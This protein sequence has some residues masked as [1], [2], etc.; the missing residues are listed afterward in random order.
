MCW[1]CSL[2]RD[3]LEWLQ[4]ATW[5]NVVVPQEKCFVHG[6][7]TNIWVP[8]FGLEKEKWAIINDKGLQSTMRITVSW[9]TSIWFINLFICG[10]FEWVRNIS[11][12]KME[13]SHALSL[14][15]PCHTANSHEVRLKHQLKF[16]LWHL[17]AF[18]DLLHLWNL[19]YKIS[20]RSDVLSLQNQNKSKPH[21]LL[22]TLQA[23]PCCTAHVNGVSWAGDICCCTLPKV[24]HRVSLFHPQRYLLFISLFN[25]HTFYISSIQHIQNSHNFCGRWLSLFFVCT[26]FLMWF[27]GICILIMLGTRVLMMLDSS[28]SSDWLNNPFSTH[29]D[30]KATQNNNK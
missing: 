19:L 3:S 11:Q 7:R 6:F 10:Y 20:S 24:S 15:A 4:D 22:N 16:L 9:V 26:S 1:H 2:A 12:Y 29:K 21:Y 17:R 28:W 8:G 18:L 30:Y 13:Q 14:R 27:L 23:L 5:K 25:K